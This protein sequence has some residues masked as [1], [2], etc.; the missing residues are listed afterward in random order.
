M[1]NIRIFILGSSIVLS[2]WLTAAFFHTTV[3][4]APTPKPSVA[5]TPEP[6]ATPQPE[7][8]ESSERQQTGQSD[9][10]SKA[11]EPIARAKQNS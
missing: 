11:S 3:R 8:A 1:K 5:V 4:T 9:T 10:D 7:H 6:I 2:A